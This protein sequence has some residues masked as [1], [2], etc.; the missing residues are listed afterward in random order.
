MGVFFEYY[1]NA[2]SSGAHRIFF[3]TGVEYSLTD[4]LS[5]GLIT[6]HEAIQS[7][8]N[9]NRRVS[10]NPEFIFWLALLLVFAYAQISKL[11]DII[12]T[13]KLLSFH[14]DIEN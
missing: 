8:L 14:H 10:P 5:M 3:D 1:L 12:W 11:I 9:V 4:A 6:I 13:E 7:G 2:S